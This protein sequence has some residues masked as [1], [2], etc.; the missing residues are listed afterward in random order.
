MH[1]YVHVLITPN[2]LFSLRPIGSAMFRATFNMF[3]HV[4][5]PLF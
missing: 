4:G 1:K 2:G 5:L 3:T